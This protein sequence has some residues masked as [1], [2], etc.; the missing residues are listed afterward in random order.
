MK[1]KPVKKIVAKKGGGRKAPPTPAKKKAPPPKRQPLTR[2]VAD[3]LAKNPPKPARNPVLDYVHDSTISAVV[4]RAI[5]MGIYTEGERKSAHADLRLIHNSGTR[6]D[7]EALLKYRDD[8][9]HHDVN[10]M[11]LRLDRP[12][13]K[14]IAFFV[15]R[16]VAMPSV[17]K[18]G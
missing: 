2:A 17:L 9:F 1:K 7:F 6:L 15:P 4:T 3:E 13:G 5:K 14:L 16:C 11:K 10:G 18:R 12:T 8:D